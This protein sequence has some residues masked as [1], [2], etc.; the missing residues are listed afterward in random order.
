MDIAGAVDIGGDHFL[1][2]VYHWEDERATEVYGYQDHH[3]RPDGRAC[4]G[5]VK[6][7]PDGPGSNRWASSGSL[8]DGTLTL[9]PSLL[10]RACGDHGWVRD[11]RWVKA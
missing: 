1:V 2:P 5:F 4:Q 8:A 3:R 10:C 11:G 9:D 6:V 7:S